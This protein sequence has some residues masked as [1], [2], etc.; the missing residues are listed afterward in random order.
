MSDKTDLWKRTAAD[1]ASGIRQKE[2]T[3]VEVLE[4]TLDRLDAVNPALN[5]VVAEMPDEART[6][7]EAVDRRIAQG[8]DP[9]ILGGVPVTIKVNI[10]Q[11]GHATTNGLR[12]QKD[13]IA[14][15]DSPVVANFRK[16]GAVIVGRTNTPAFSTRWFTRNDLHGW[17]K[18]PR[19]PGLT[20]GGSSGGA[21][22]AVAAGI[23]AIA[24]GTDIAGSIRYP[25][26]A[27]GVHGL[28][29]SFGRIP[30][31]N[32]TT[33]DR[34]IG[35]Q[36]MA[37]SGPLARSVDDLR[38]GFDALNQP[39][40]RDAW[41]V[42]APGAN[43]A[44][45]KKAALCIAPEG[46][47]V[48]PAV[49]SALNAAADHLRDAGW[50]VEEKP[51]PPLRAMSDI[52]VILWMADFQ[53]SVLPA[54]KEEGNA[55]ALFVQDQLI[56]H[57][58]GPAT[59]ERVM[60]A[61]QAR[62]GYVRQWQE[63]LEENPL[64]LLPVSAEPPFPDQ[65]DVESPEAFDR[66]FEAQLTQVALPLAGM[67]AMTVTTQSHGNGTVGVQLVSARFRED[68]LFEAGKTLEAAGTPP[69]PVDPAGA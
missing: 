9:G 41:Y 44:Y 8:E 12:L 61:L 33:P 55:D 67:P 7:A 16:S 39:D 51:C 65:L 26:Y 20:P 63:F 32:T 18:N 35:A 21:G 28:R 10:D 43:P 52:Q 60:D 3:A 36:I 11:Q 5:A 49:V 17:T 19:D 29:P 1:L 42:P 58:K 30:A 66:V 24:H 2:F 23:G 25:A 45:P 13:L 54:L 46:L 15:R 47:A 53:R 27:N 59:F 40:P 34:H 62:F 14:D 64:L 6:A 22:S 37:V 4:A 31:V 56:R 38:L 68:I 48:D 57:A 69:S 50:A